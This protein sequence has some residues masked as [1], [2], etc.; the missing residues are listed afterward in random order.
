MTANPTKHDD[1]GGTVA[2]EPDQNIL[3]FGVHA[4]YPNP[5]G[6]DGITLVLTAPAPMGWAQLRVYDLLG[7]HVATAFEGPLKS[8]EY[9]VRLDTTP[10]PAGVY[11]FVMES[12]ENRDYGRFLVG[13]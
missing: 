7:R 9:P 10:L 1:D 6:K 2:T 8:G 4:V 11:V 5:A 13:E 3:E 12:D